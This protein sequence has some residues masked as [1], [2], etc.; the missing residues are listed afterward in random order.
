MTIISKPFLFILCVTIAS[1]LCAQNADALGEKMGKNYCDSLTQHLPLVYDNEAYLKVED[2]WDRK[3]F[4]LNNPDVETYLRLTAQLKPENG[5]LKKEAFLKIAQKAV[6]GCDFFMA[7]LGK[8]SRNK[9]IK[10]SLIEVNDKVCTCLESKMGNTTYEEFFISKLQEATV[11]MQTCTA[12]NNTIESREK[13]VKEYEIKD[14]AGSLRYG[15]LSAG[16]LFTHCSKFANMFA[17][18]KADKWA[19]ILSVQ[20]R[21]D[22]SRYAWKVVNTIRKMSKD[23]I[24]NQFIDS[25]R[26]Y[27]SLSEILKAQYLLSENPYA[28][29][30][31]RPKDNEEKSKRAVQKFI[32][33]NDIKTLFVLV[34]EYD[35]D[36]YSKIR[37]L[38]VLT[39]QNIKNLK[40]LD[41]EI[42]M[43]PPPPP[44]P[45]PPLMPSK[46]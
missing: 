3:V 23:T 13:I 35:S 30:F 41:D 2:D 5:A 28:S 7:T 1:P 32:F 37:T 11:M 20:I 24:E 4:N 33:T 39:R 34:V 46:N 26:F 16:Y 17:E 22:Y 25:K 42:K 21:K 29:C 36:A 27:K 40:E 6:K 31:T 45:P 44:P 43:A 19:G 12:N 18:Q 8:G 14:Q 10:P 9:D 38:T 15:H